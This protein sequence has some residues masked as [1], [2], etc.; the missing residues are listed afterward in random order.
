MKPTNALFS[1]APFNQGS[2]FCREGQFVVGSYYGQEFSGTV[3]L[4]RVKYGGGI[5]H[6]V[7]LLF[8]IEV[9][10]ET[11]EIILCNEDEIQGAFIMIKFQE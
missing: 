11:R 3:T 7:E 5:Q 1:K 9:H 2:N 6:T 8:P 4:S 10:M